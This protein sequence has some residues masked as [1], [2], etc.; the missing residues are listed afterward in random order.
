M[1]RVMLSVAAAGLLAF[2]LV[3]P[4]AAGGNPH[5]ILATP[6]T[7]CRIMV[8]YQVGGYTSFDD[9]M[10]NLHGDMAAYR[11][12]DDADPTKLLTLSERC[13][14][15]EQGVYDEMAGGLLQISYPF[16]FEEFPGW[17]FPTL[18]GQNHQQCITTL[19][20]YHNLASLLFGPA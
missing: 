18:T 16:Y 1:K 9:C 7:A 20:T 13:T 3:G 15:L 12:P 2:A 19:F 14:Q 17:P 4:V 6:S 5:R 10:G 11:F 8:Q